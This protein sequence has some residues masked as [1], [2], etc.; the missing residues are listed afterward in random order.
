M[1]FDKGIKFHIAIEEDR[2]NRIE[3]LISHPMAKN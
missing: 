2:S 1:I 3:Y